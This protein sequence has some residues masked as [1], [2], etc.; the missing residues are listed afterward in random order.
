MNKVWLMCRLIWL[1]V[2]GIMISDVVPIRSVDLW[3]INNN[4][5]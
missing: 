2:G 5:E 3:I 4:T 1:I